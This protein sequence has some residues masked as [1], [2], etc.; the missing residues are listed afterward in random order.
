[1]RAILF[2]YSFSSTNVRISANQKKDTKIQF[3]DWLNQT[4]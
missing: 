1:M 3:S 2:G 4:I